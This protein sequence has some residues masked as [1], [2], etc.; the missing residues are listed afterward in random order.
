MSDAK[1][2]VKV[3]LV[4]L[5]RMPIGDKLSLRVWYEEAQRL[6]RFCS[7]ED[8]CLPTEVT[9]WL[10]SADA[11]GQDPLRNATEAADLARYLQTLP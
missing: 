3:T 4:E 5:M 11:R 9:K 10:A 7:K 6:M 8:V 1:A 2:H